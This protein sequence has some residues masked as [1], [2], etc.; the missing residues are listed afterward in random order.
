[1][2]GSYRR[3]EVFGL[4][5][6]GATSCALGAAFWDDLLSETAVA[7]RPN[8]YG[9]L[10]SRDRLGLRLPRGFEVRLIA[11]GGERNTRTNR[12]KVLYDAD[13]VTRPVLIHVDA[14]TGS[15]TAS[16]SSARTTTKA[17]LTSRSSSVPAAC[18]GCCRPPDPATRI[19]S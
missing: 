12:I 11:R 9:P 14:L 2:D 3:R 19:Q 10:G 16:S 1:M 4:A 17:G 7:A 6:G 15:P 13:R 8:V 5:L 18:R